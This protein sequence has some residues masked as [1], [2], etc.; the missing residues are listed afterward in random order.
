VYAYASEC[1]C[2]TACVYVN[3]LMFELDSAANISSLD[4]IIVGIDGSRSCASAPLSL[5]TVPVCCLPSFLSHPH[6]P[7][8]HY[9]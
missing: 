3:K 9:D 1:V 4:L 5:P 8:T 2:A 7:Y 6:P